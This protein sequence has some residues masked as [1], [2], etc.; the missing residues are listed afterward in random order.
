MNLPFP[1][2]GSRSTAGARR[3]FTLVEMLVVIAVIGLLAAMIVP[4]AGLASKKRNLARAQ[5]EINNLALAIDNYKVK[6]GYYP[7][8]NPTQPAGAFTNQLFYEL[9]GMIAPA[10]SG[11]PFTNTLNASAT[12]AAGFETISTATL[13]QFFNIKGIVNA[14]PDTNEIINFISRL[15]AS[16]I[17]N[18]NI[19]ASPAAPVWVFAVPMAGPLN[20]LPVPSNNGTN[21][22]PVNVIRYVS[23]NPTN[24][25]TTYD[26]WVDILIAGKT[27]RISNWSKDSQI[28][29][30]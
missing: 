9:W 22:A 26:L 7:P 25:P 15:G 8:D 21:Y 14:S 11:N 27:N 1:S 13:A 2:I 6:K 20:G 4:L 3:G 5:T 18:I 24:N 29:N 12:G 16:E 30:Y 23:T 28:V 19:G 10:V 17:Q